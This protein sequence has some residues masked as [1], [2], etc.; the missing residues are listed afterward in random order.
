MSESRVFVF[1]YRCETVVPGRMAAMETAILERDFGSFARLTMQDSNQF[2]AVCLDSYPPIVYL[3]DTSKR[4]M[5]LVTGFNE[6]R[7]QEKVH[8]SH[9]HTHTHTNTHTHTHSSHTHTHTHMHTHTN[10][11]THRWPI[12]LMLVRTQFSTV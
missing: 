7:Q 10:T 8:S 5:Q 6:V 9:I 3:T 4:V 2:H 11:L 1:Q 12:H